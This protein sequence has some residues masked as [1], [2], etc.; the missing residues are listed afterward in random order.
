MQ[1]GHRHTIREPMT[2][3]P[4]PRPTARVLLLDEEDRI[5]LIYTDGEMSGIGLPN[6]WLTPGGGVESGESYEEAAL[7]ELVEEVA[8][9]HVALGPCIWLRTFPFARDGVRY[10][11]QERYFV[12]RVDHF[13]ID[14]AAQ[15]D[16]ANVVGY[17]WWSA[18]EIEASSDLFASRTLGR[19]LGPV[20]RGEI[21][22]EPV[23]VGV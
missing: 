22:G 5:F 12:C 1:A 7:R 11:K 18:D 21:P 23:D 16:V 19:L 4:I 6:V 17:K 10:A 20:L 3:L 13:E 14:G 15:V 9:D 8:L 2:N